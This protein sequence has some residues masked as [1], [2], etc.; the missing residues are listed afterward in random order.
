MVSLDVIQPPTARSPAGN[1]FRSWLLRFY[2]VGV[3]AAIVVILH[4]HAARLRI[5]GDS[6]ITVEE[7]LHFFPTA[8][9][10]KTD[11]SEKQGLF[12]LDSNNNEI[13]YLLRTAPLTNRI[14]GYRGPTDTLIALNNDMIVIG[15]RVRSSDDTKQHVG[16]VIT[17]K[18]FMKRWTGKTWEQVAGMTPKASRIEG[19]SSATLTSMCI[20]N[21][22]QQ[23]FNHS[24]ENTIHKPK[25]HFSAKDYGLIA[26]IVVGLLFAFTSLRGNMTCR[27]IFQVVLIGYLGL[28]NGQ[29]LAESLFF[30]WSASEIPWQIAPGLTLLAAVALAVPWL[31]RRAVY[32]SQICPHGAAQELL[33]KI[34]TRRLAIPPRIE[35]GLRWLPPLL[36][37]LML[38]VSVHQLPL[39]LAG[40]EPFD[41]WCRVGNIKIDHFWQ[42]ARDQLFQ[43]AGLGTMLVAIVGL[44]ISVFVPMGYC[45]YAC[46]TGWVLSLV[47]SHGNAD[48]FGT[49]DTAA[50][51]LLLF[52]VLLYTTHSS[53]AHLILK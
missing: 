43:V 23:R 28:F 24:F 31:F 30:G 22:I 53:V 12:V 34:T 52:T 4:F 6:P 14:V 2:R 36:M 15:I 29:L 35:K 26:V 37:G 46:P 47:R 5:D 7:S 48:R 13:G 21:G 38:I 33:G 42:S 51:A 40:T 17:D 45:K 19:V 44:I 32:C 9:K 10:L 3:L 41:A 8:T 27:R 25:L 50:M 49:R 39:D 16:D 1:I 20:V 18:Y 11:L